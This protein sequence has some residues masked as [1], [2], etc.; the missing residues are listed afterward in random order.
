MT[1]LSNAEI[2]DFPK[3]RSHSYDNIKYSFKFI[4]ASSIG[5]KSLKSFLISFLQNIIGV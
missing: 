3:L 2:V 5:T 4:I 1:R